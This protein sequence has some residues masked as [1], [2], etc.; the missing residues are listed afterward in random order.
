MKITA[1]VPAD[2]STGVGLDGL[3]RITFDEPVDV[4]TFSDTCVV[5]KDEAGNLVEFTTSFENSNLELV[6]KPASLLN[7]SETYKLTLSRL[8][9]SNY[10]IITSTYGTQLDDDLVISFTTT[11]GVS[12]TENL[13][14]TE[15]PLLSSEFAPADFT[16]KIVD[17]SPRNTPIS[18]NYLSVTFNKEIDLSQNIYELIEVTKEN[19]FGE[20]VAFEPSDFAITPYGK[21]LKII[22]NEELESNSVVTVEISPNFRAE[23]TSV[24][25]DVLTV[26]FFTGLKPSLSSIGFLR[27]QLGILGKYVDDNTIYISV[28][29][30]MTDVERITGKSIVGQNV[31]L[32]PAERNYVTT[33]AIQIVLERISMEKAVFASRVM[34]GSLSYDDVNSAVNKML[35]YFAKRVAEKEQRLTEEVMRSA[36]Y[37]STAIRGINYPKF[38]SRD[39]TID[40]RNYR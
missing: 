30:A 29:E 38:F 26:N 8:N 22:F 40:G 11:S 2:G 39:W 18:S 33:R 17:W 21:T 35:D 12:V 20:I 32:T 19:V 15:N 7:A 36:G 16:F 6:I 25:G 4:S 5:Y 9:Y 10:S 13:T 28:L 24:A 23:D 1:V 31:E 37:T 3:V 34:I 14:P 27:H